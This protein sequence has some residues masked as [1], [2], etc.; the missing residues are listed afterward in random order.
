MK[1]SLMAAMLLAVFGLAEAQTPPAAPIWAQ[2]RERA[3][4]D[5]K[6]APLAGKNTSKRESHRAFGG[7]LKMKDTPKDV[8]D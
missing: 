1:K 7:L 2:G 3:M 6:L 5:S 4:A 8:T